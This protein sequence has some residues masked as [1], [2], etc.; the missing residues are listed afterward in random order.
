MKEGDT[1]KRLAIGFA[2]LLLFSGAAVAQTDWNSSPYNWKNSPYNWEN[3]P[4][5]YEN[6]PLNYENSPLKWNNE[7]IIRDNQGKDTGLYCVPRSDGGYNIFDRGGN[8]QGYKPGHSNNDD[9]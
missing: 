4:M 2:V 9:W 7:R 3:S 1:M 5:N 8:R 6:S